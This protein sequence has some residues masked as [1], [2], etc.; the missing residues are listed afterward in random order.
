MVQRRGREEREVG[1]EGMVSDGGG[2]RRG[3]ERKGGKGGRKGGILAL[4]RPY[5]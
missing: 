1:M 2:G 3:M 5:I 4:E